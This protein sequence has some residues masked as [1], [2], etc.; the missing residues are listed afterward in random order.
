MDAVYGMSL[1]DMVKK[2][3]EESGNAGITALCISRNLGVEKRRVNNVLY[4]MAN[5]GEV[6]RSEHTPPIWRNRHVEENECSLKEFS[7]VIPQKK[8]LEWQ[9]KNPLMVLNEYS[10]LTGRKIDYQ[11]ITKGEL[12]CPIFVCRVMIDGRGFESVCERTKKESKQSAA[13]LALNSVFMRAQIQF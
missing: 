4:S 10:Q 8:Y 12:H 3:V 6:T 7:D 2:E 1:W 11:I 9:N 13:K 5:E